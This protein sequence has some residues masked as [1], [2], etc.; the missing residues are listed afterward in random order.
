MSNLQTVQTN[1]FR[2]KT[3]KTSFFLIYQNQLRMLS[4]FSKTHGNRVT[5]KRVLFEFEKNLVTPQRV[6]SENRGLERVKK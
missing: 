6:L 4:N 2:E 1:T 5:G 3:P